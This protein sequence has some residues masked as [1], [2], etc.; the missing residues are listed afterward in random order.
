MNE[1]KRGTAI[2]I[3]AALLVFQAVPSAGA[4]R[5]S[6]NR[7]PRLEPPGFKSSEQRAK[8]RPTAEDLLR[9]LRKRRPVPEV[10]QPVSVTGRIEGLDD[11]VLVPE[12]TSVVDR[13]GRLRRDGEDWVFVSKAQPAGD[14]APTRLL[15]SANL[16]VMVRT[17]RGSRRPVTFVVSGEMTVFQGRNH[18]LIRHVRRSDRAERAARARLAKPPDPDPSAGAV[19]PPANPSEPGSAVD[20][21]SVLQQARPDEQPLRP[22]PLPARRQREREASATRTLIPEGTPMVRRPGRLVLDGRSWAFAF[23]SDSTEM[24]EPPMRVLANLNTELMVRAAEGAIA[25]Q[26]F[27]VSG[28]VTLFEGENY[29]LPRVAMRRIGAGNFRK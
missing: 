4:L 17:A 19:P 8:V 24:P 16:E 5:A 22:D 25:G 28:E 21:L 12:G 13:V 1:A 20:V 15:P 9:E 10:I 18:L 3:A 7:P 11:P 26:V 2:A 14:N 6:S 29:L 27:I 23:E